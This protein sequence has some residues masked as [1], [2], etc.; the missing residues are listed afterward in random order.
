MKHLT[1]RRKEMT[2]PTIKDICRVTGLSLGTVSKYLNGGSLRDRNRELIDRAIAE[3]GYRTD[4]YARGMITKRTKTVGVLLPEFDNLFYARI[5]SELETQLSKCGYAVMVRESRWN[6]EKERA[7]VEWFVTHRVDALVVVPCEH[8]EEAY[9]YLADISIPVVFLDHYVPDVKC[10][11]V[12]VDNRDVSRR[13]V[14]YLLDS[15]HRKVAV[16]AAPQGVYTS[17]E[18]V[19]GYCDAFTERGLPIDG[20]LIYHVAEDI[21][22]AYVLIK[23]I[24]QEKRCTAIFTSNFPTTYGLIFSLTELRVRVP[25]EMSVLGFDDMMFTRMYRPK[26]TII[27]Q[28]IREIVATTIARLFELW[29]QTHYDYHINELKCDFIINESTGVLN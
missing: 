1:K 12:L 5:S 8:T 19:K 21:D 22:D 28:P 25:E 16:V 3:L 7:S 18:R 24:L 11:F 15:G 14:G 10:E 6:A 9:R 27:D 29:G 26:L 13:S 17:D 23:K 4:E 2:K 20:S